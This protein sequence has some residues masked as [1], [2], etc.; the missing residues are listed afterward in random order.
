MTIHCIKS[1]SCC[2]SNDSLNLEDG[3]TAG[4]SKQ[5]SNYYLFIFSI[6]HFIFHKPVS[7]PNKTIEYTLDEFTVAFSAPKENY[8]SGLPK[9]SKSTAMIPAGIKSA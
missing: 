7:L 6:F 9:R 4:S 8:S 1:G 5:S 3:I 2:T